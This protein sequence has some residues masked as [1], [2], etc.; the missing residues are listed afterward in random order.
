MAAATVTRTEAHVEIADLLHQ[1]REVMAASRPRWSAADLTFTQLRALSAIGKRES[2]RV[3]ELGDDL[4]I[5]LAAAS[6]L[7]DRMTR[8]Q[9]IVRRSDP[10]DRRIVRLELSARGRHLLERLERGRM[11]VF[12]KLIAHM[13]PSERTALAT[14]LRAFVRL[15]AEYGVQ[16][17]PSGLVTVRRAETC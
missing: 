15:G 17:E 5:G 16:K 7:A 8:R 11:E 1:W 12:G 6:A 3:T 9:F 14:T 13:T 4:G 10:N 2:M